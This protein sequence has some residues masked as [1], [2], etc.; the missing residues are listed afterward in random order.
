MI[1]ASIIAS[2][3]LIALLEA[4]ALWRKQSW[5]ELWTVC[6]LL[7]AGA[8]LSVAQALHLPIPNPV[9]WITIIF[10]PAS[11]VVTRLLS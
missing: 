2:A 4:P 8:F 10:K 1:V 7:T 9:G 11:E 6:V 3:V 5:K